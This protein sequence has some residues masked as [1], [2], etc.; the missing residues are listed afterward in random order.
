MSLLSR[1]LDPQFVSLK[2]CG[3]TTQQDAEKLAA[4][5]VAALGI[6][7]WPRSKRYF[8]E[9]N[10]PW[11]KNLAGTILRVGV[12]VN[13]PVAEAVQLYEQGLI[14]VVQLHGDETPADAAL[15]RELEIPWIKAI[16]VKSLADLSSASDYG[17]TAILLD[18]HAPGVYGG[19]GEQLDWEI[20]QQFRAQQ[21]QIPLI[22][23]GGIVPKNAAL[24]AQSVVPAALD[25]AS[26]GE[27]SPGV[28]DFAKVAAFLA[29]LKTPAAC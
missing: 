20:A 22:L 28:K 8:S 14:D 5:G 21:P 15:L 4:L 27:I 10:S 17:A 12:F 24:A 1:F 18:A 3:V 29:A 2:I 25:V 19:T 9:A 6:N 11:L 16:G 13:Q 26:G 7:F 23:A